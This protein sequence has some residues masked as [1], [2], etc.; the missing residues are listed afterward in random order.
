[1]E[2]EFGLVCPYD[3]FSECHMSN[4]PFWGIIATG[5]DEDDNQMYVKGCR[6]AENELKGGIDAKNN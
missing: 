3:R 2:N 4:C 6:R 1:M 5:Y